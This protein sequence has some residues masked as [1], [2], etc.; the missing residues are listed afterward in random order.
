MDFK[1]NS[2]ILEFRMIQM[3]YDT[4]SIPELFDNIVASA[5]VGIAIGLHHP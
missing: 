2:P 5:N 1:D 3:S 4:G